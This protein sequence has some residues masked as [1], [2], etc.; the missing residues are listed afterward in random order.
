MRCRTERADNNGIRADAWRVAQCDP[1]GHHVCDGDPAGGI[2]RHSHDFPGTGRMAH[3]EESRVDATRARTRDAGL[4]HR[5][6]RRQDRHADAKPDD[7][8]RTAH[9]RDGNSTSRQPPI[10]RCR[11][12]STC[13]SSLR[14]SRASAIRS[15]RWTRRSRRPSNGFS[16]APNTFIWTG[17]SSTS[18]RCRGSCWP[19]RGYGA[20]PTGATT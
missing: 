4:G 8:H 7:A 20:R 11:S 19:S 12:I 9:A 18:I 13:S 1:D 16:P 2:A 10:P 5:P 14:C 17:R 6:L 15:T 3:R